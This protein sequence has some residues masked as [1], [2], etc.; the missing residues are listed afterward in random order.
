MRAAGMEIGNHGAHHLQLGRVPADQAAAEVLEAQRTIGAQL[1]EP[2]LAL[3][4]PGG[5]Y[6]DGAVAAV[7]AAGIVVA[8][9]TPQ[10]RHAYTW[11]DRLL[12]PRINVGA[13]SD[14]ERLAW[15]VESYGR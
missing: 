9:T 10:S 13:Q 8:F 6:D 1:G 4:Y 14:G 7:R 3:A 5:S 15:T 11:T 12:I 2:P